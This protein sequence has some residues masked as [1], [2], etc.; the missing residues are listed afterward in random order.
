MVKK[1][2]TARA[3]RGSSTNITQQNMATRE[4]RLSEFNTGT[5]PANQ[6]FELLCEDH[7]GTYT[8]PF[9]CRWIDGAWVGPRNDR[10]EATV[11]GWHERR[12]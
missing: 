3:E 7:R 1:R 8:L 10:I 12:T 4:Y 6:P 9:A 2:L 11:V 5:P